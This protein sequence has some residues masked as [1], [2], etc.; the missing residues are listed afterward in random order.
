[1]RLSYYTMVRTAHKLS[2]HCLGGW[3]NY[4]TVCHSTLNG[5]SVFSTSNA[6]FTSIPY[7][8]IIIHTYSLC[9]RDADRALPRMRCQLK[10]QRDF[11]T[12]LSHFLRHIKVIQYCLGGT[13]MKPL[14]MCSFSLSFP[15]SLP[16]SPSPSLRCAQETQLTH[17]QTKAYCSTR[18]GID[19]RHGIPVSPSPLLH[20]H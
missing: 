10:D 12:L 9:C 1:M 20:F 11:V 14:L 19:S 18:R 2:S 13:L 15:P 8:C 5:R 17:R 3:V 4:V 6:Y 7:L 16:P